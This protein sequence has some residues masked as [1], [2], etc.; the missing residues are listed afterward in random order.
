MERREV[1]DDRSSI[2]LGANAALF[3]WAIGVLRVAPNVAILGRF[4][5]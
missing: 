3:A 1:L 4:G 2:A 5:P